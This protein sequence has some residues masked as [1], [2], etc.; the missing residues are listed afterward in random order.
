MHP[1][2]THFETRTS[3]DVSGSF[4][5]SYPPHGSQ[6]HS[7]LR[8]NRVEDRLRSLEELISSIAG[9]AGHSNPVAPDTLSAGEVQ[10]I[11][12][13]AQTSESPTDIPE[14]SWINYSPSPALQ[15]VP[16][17]NDRSLDRGP[18]P[19]DESVDPNNLA[20]DLNQG[21]MHMDQHGVAGPSSWTMAST[22][23]FPFSSWEIS[24][25]AQQPED[26]YPR[27]EPPAPS[28]A[29]FVRSRETPLTPDRDLLYR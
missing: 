10:R 14:F 23:L 28:G 26:T 13:A 16:G 18:S 27:Y 17:T 12:D 4:G 22:S 15:T 19:I 1:L 11:R 9:G 24:T 21:L 3:P 25:H 5:L 2:C 29:A 8:S 6:R 7:A 20:R